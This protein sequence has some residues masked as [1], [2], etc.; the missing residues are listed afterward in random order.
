MTSLGF[1]VAWQNQSSQTSYILAGLPPRVSI[2]RSL[3]GTCQVSWGLASEVT[4]CHLAMFCSPINHI[5]SQ[6]AWRNRLHLSVREW[7]TQLG[8]EVI[9]GNKLLSYHSSLSVSGPTC[10]FW[11]YCQLLLETSL[12]WSLTLKFS[13]S[14]CTRPVCVYPSALLY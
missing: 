1:L 8:K 12:P 14:T 4:Q 9:F 6:R 3:G 7:L 5:P 13:T 2:L 11:S 10:L